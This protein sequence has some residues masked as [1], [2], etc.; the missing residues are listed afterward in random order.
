MKFINRQKELEFLEKKWLSHVP[1][2]V[3]IYGKRRVGKTELIKNF[4]K[5]KTACYFLADKRNET[6]QLKELGQLI[7]QHFQD[8]ILISRGFN[9]WLEVFQYLKEKAKKPFILVID[10]FPYLVE[11]NKAISSLFQKGWDD[12]L[13]DTNVFLII[14]GSSM[15]MMETETLIYKSPL[16]GRRTGQILLKPFLFQE[17]RQFFPQKSFSEFLAIFTIVGGIPAYLLEID[18]DIS[19]RENIKEKIFSKTEFLHNEIEFILKEELREPKNYLAILRAIS[20]NKHKF[21]EISN[22]TGLARNILTKYLNTLERLQLV[23][24]EITVT[25]KNPAK[26]KKGL[27]KIADNYFNFWFKYIFPYKSFL[28]ME[29]YLEINRKIKESFNILQSLVYE[30]VCRELIWDWQNK[31][32]P[33]ERVGRWWDREKEIDIVAVNSPTNQIL[34]G[35]AKWTKKQIGTNIYQDLKKKAKEVRWGDKKRQE[36]YILFSKNGFTKDMK[37]IAQEEKVFLVEQAKI[38]N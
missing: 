13:K 8:S 23:I 15:A 17:A 14:S 5:N 22:E 7:G 10:E 12:Y 32:F 35:E 16:Y 25:E 38:V 2:L 18:P 21:S 29:R 34:F 11:N 30:K 20:L 37:K 6:E 28:E 31:I 36:Y 3:I 26:S 27:Y 4:I 33:L 1:Q 24:K 9:N 19:W